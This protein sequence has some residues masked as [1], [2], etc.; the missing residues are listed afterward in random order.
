LYIQ[1]KTGHVYL[2]YA[3]SKLSADYQVAADSN[4]QVDESKNR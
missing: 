3:L 4:L 1:Q 2:Y